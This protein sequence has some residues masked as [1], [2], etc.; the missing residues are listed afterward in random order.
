VPSQ[1]RA[2]TLAFICA[3]AALMV[4][5]WLV[6]E[7]LRGQTPGFDASVRDDVHAWAFP[8]LT[9]V[10][11]GATYMASAWFVTG[12]GLLAVWRLTAAGRGRAAALL[13]ASTLGAE[14]LDQILK[15]VFRRPRPEAFL[16]FPD[17]ITY[18]FPSGHAFTSCCFYCLLSALLVARM[19]S[20]PAKAGLWTL[21]GAL[22]AAIGFS[23]VYL[24]VH[25]LS[26]V[27]AGY[28]A[29]VIWLAA[30][31]IGYSVWLQRA[32]AGP[33]DPTDRI[34]PCGSE[35]SPSGRR[36]GCR[37][38]EGGRQSSDLDGWKEGPH[39]G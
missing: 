3:A 13:A 15:L 1:R 12:V 9:Y 20:V 14:A 5:G 32:Q 28:S 30:V 26:D 18:S 25:Y 34:E 27:L 23:R 24:G 33:P 19:R 39:G 6:N 37:R 2:I 11:K 8:G 7:V 17:P 4:F 36:A 35:P 16:G 22:A 10:M 21:T 38:R 29:A 31:R